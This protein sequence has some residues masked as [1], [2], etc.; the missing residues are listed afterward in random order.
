M[1]KARS[2]LRKNENKNKVGNRKAGNRNTEKNLELSL[3]RTYPRQAIWQVIIPAEPLKFTTTITTGVLA[4]IYGISQANIAGFSTRFGSTFVEYR[5]IRA[6]F[7]IRFFSST[8]PGIVQFWIDEK[9]N[10]TPTVNEAFERA[11]LSCSASAVD[12]T[13]QMKWV[14]ADPLDLQYVP[15][16]TA[17]TLATFKMYTDNTNFGSS[18][19]ATDY[20]EIVPLFEFQFR[21]LK[22]V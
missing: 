11:T 15:I 12:T 4:Q 9:S 8:N 2:N 3:I 18:I 5:I 14:C 10:S 17:V 20:L 19:V 16:G 6:K 7:M 13:P 21:G 1:Q 22:G